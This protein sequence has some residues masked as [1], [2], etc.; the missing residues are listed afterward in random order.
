MAARVAAQAKRS[1]EA[2]RSFP[3]TGPFARAEAP[4]CR[5][6]RLWPAELHVTTLE[7]IMVR[8]LQPG[9][10]R[11][12]DSA[13]LSEISSNCTTFAARSR[14]A[15]GVLLALAR[16]AVG[17]RRL[18]LAPTARKDLIFSAA[19]SLV[20]AL[21]LR[22]PPLRNNCICTH[23]SSAS[24]LPWRSEYERPHAALLQPIYMGQSRSP[25]LSR[26]ARSFALL[27]SSAVSLGPHKFLTVGF[28]EV[29][30]LGSASA[31]VEGFAPRAPLPM[32]DAATSALPLDAREDFGHEPAVRDPEV[33]GCGARG[34]R[35]ESK[36]LNVRQRHGLPARLLLQEPQGFLYSS[37]KNRQCNFS[38]TSMSTVRGH[39]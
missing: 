38:Q 9:D 18:S 7:P 36:E 8:T 30:G 11:V 32:S 6:P 35:R 33:E 15:I 5:S 37:S 14:L 16:L 3:R 26:G 4:T 20:S 21:I 10:L 12:V 25:S 27:T 19:E 22:K 13:E 28:K 29:S 23:G 24:S 31:C 1:S 34:I 39:L 2:S 17:E